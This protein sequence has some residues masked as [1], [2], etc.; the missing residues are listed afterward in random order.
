MLKPF[1]ILVLL[2]IAADKPA[3]AFRSQL[4]ESARTAA[5]R[6]VVIESARTA[7]CS[8][9]AI[10]ERTTVPFTKEQLIAM[11]KNYTTN[12]SPDSMAEDFIFRGPVIGPLTKSDIIKT[13]KTVGNG[14]DVAFPDINPNA[15]GFTADDPIEPM[16]VWYFVR[17]RGTFSG[18]FTHPILGEI[19]PTGK[20]LI[21]PPEARSMLFNDEGKIKMTTVGYVTDRFT[22]DTTGGN[23]AVFGLY[24]V[25]GQGIDGRVGAPLTSL[26][27]KLGEFLPGLPASYSR[28]DSSF[29]RW[30]KDSR[31]GAEP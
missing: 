21:G 9:A 6:S 29:P 4:I 27:Q 12:P 17:P 26:I 2:A 14:I 20:K 16:R 31:N 11:A 1:I 30:W 25:M 13:L 18:P 22:G 28:R 10:V 15:F 8:S 7:L 19:K 23:G 5:F 24:H 3:A